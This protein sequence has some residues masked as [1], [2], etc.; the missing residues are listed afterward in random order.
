VAI[1]ALVS[2]TVFDFVALIPPG[3]VDLRL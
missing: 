3:P 1:V 2:I